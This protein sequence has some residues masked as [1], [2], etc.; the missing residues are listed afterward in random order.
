M[1]GVDTNV[2]VRFFLN[3]EER[4]SEFARRFLKK[5]TEEKA[6]F[7]SSYAILELAWVLKMKKRSRDEI[8][9]SIS[10]L[11]HSAG[12]VVGER[13]VVVRALKLFTDGKNDFGDYFILAQ[14]EEYGVQ[15]LATFDF[16]LI[17]ENPHSCSVPRG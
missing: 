17:H 8:S 3:D 13:E 7:V 4:D 11:V 9:N 16:K 5:H 10:S 14:G 12:I 6:L 1:I 15:K 2:L